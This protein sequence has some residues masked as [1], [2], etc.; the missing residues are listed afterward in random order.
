[1]NSYTYFLFSS[2][3]W[4]KVAK[5]GF[6]FNIMASILCAIFIRDA[7]LIVLVFFGLNGLLLYQ[8]YEDRKKIFESNRNMELQRSQLPSEANRLDQLFWQCDHC[9]KFNS[10]KIAT[11]QVCGKVR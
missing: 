4:R 5:Y 7:D 1:M 3:D 11:C 6:A 8:L 9:G 10:V 2:D